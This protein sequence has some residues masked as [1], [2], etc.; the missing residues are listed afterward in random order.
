MIYHVPKNQWLIKIIKALI[1][2]LRSNK[3]KFESQ[4]IRKF[5]I[6]KLGLP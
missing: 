1:Y 3:K 5:M 6:Q 4:E 2:V